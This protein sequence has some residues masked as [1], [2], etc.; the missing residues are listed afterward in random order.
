MLKVCQLTTTT[1]V[2]SAT[3]IAQPTWYMS[4]SPRHH[5]PHQCASATPSTTCNWRTIFLS[6]S[7]KGTNFNPITV[8]DWILDYTENFTPG[9]TKS[10]LHLF[11]LFEHLNSKTKLSIG[12]FFIPRETKRCNFFSFAHYPSFVTSSWL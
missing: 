9:T 12:R 3:C 4:P 11:W 8:S 6:A 5:N 7:L 1:D 2:L 10:S